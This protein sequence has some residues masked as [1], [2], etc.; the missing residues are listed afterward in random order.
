M[1][2]IFERFMRRQTAAPLAVPATTTSRVLV[3]GASGSI[4]AAIAVA[5]AAAG[6]RVYL[7]A[8]R[9]GDRVRRLADGLN[10]AQG[11]TVA[12]SGSADLREPDAARHLVAAAAQALGGLDVLAIAIGSARDAPLPL[13]TADDLDAA[14]RDNLLP[15][16]HACEAFRDAWL[17][18]PRAS[19]AL[20]RIVVVSSVTGQVGQP[21]RVAYGAAKGAVISWTKSL[22]R[23]VAPLGI[24]ANIVA[25]QVIDGGIADLMK[26]RVRAVLLANTPLGRACSAEDVAQGVTWLASPGAAFVTGTVLGI[27]GGLVTW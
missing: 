25:P 2:A 11:S 10:Q 17:A 4:G 15:V 24:T 3:C 18:A 19:K 27:S 9:H 5:F 22:A 6:S 23:E 21:M 26:A 20:G 16:V 14:M 13:V 1:G 8:H 12:A 7:H